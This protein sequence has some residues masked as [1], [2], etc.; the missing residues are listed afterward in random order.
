MQTF[1]VKVSVFRQGERQETVV[2]V[3]ETA[4]LNGGWRTLALCAAAVKWGCSFM[5][6]S[7]APRFGIR[8]EDRQR[9]QS[10][11]RDRQEA[12]HDS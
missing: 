10:L 6:I 2:P 4:F 5:E 7:T 11:I 12:T 9:I 1:D 8:Q 3:D